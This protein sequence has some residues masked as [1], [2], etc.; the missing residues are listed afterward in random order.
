MA[1]IRVGFSVTRG[2]TAIVDSEK[3]H[4]TPASQ[5]G[6]L[7]EAAE[8]VV[9]INLED[10][11]FGVVPAET[12]LRHHRLYDDVWEQEGVCEFVVEAEGVGQ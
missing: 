9:R 4:L 2:F 7:R 3:L 6:D 8:K 10:F 11:F 5:E 12:P 1:K